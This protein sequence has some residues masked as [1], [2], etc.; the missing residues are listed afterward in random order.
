M[1]I[2]A[3]ST[4]EKNMVIATADIDAWSVQTSFQNNAKRAIL[5]VLISLMMEPK[6]HLKKLKASLVNRR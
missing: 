2:I 6:E 1:T 4:L 5:S 3:V